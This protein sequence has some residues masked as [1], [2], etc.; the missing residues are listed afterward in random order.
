MPTQNNLYDGNKMADTPKWEDSTPIE[1]STVP[2][3][4]DSTPIDSAQR[5]P[6]SE[7]SLTDQLLAG[8]A[9]YPEAAADFTSQVAHSVPGISPLV[10]GGV[11]SLREVVEGVPAEDTLSQMRA[12][13]T[14]RAKRSPIATKIGSLGGTV[15]SGLA[16]LPLSATTG[17]ALGL[18][19]SAVDQMA[20]NGELNPK[21]LGTEA[22]L[23]AGLALGAPPLLRGAAS[24]ADEL[25]SFL[26][27][28]FAKGSEGSIERLLNASG[29]EIRK[30]IIT[31]RNMANGSEEILPVTM[32][33]VAE[34]LR[35]TPGAFD[36]FIQSMK[37]RA[38][39]ADNAGLISGKAVEEAKAGRSAVNTEELTNYLNQKQSELA[40][41]PGSSTPEMEAAL[42]SVGK[43]FSD[44]TKA[45]AVG[46]TGP[47]LPEIDPSVLST[48]KA[49]FGEIYRDSG[50]KNIEA[51]NK[52]E[53]FKELERN[54]ILPENLPKYDEAARAYSID[55][56]GADRLSTAAS[57]GQTAGAPTSVAQLL[58]N[59]ANTLSAVGLNKLANA[60]ISLQA[61]RTI[62]D[63][64]EN[65][66]HAAVMSAHF[67]MMQKDK[68]YAKAVNDTNS[69]DAKTN[70]DHKQATYDTNN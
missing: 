65:R 49:E 53:I 3:W 34:K 31:K 37:S 10:E 22:A 16:A 28:K 18:G 5:M 30:D 14:A 50:R 7:S 52:E 57:K 51:G 4:E 46:N 8:L 6:E 63:A 68:E 39:A 26:K 66:G 11:A 55:Q 35:N 42:G 29:D 24:K 19:Q 59:H 40:R 27:G 33:E 61:A 23:G 64:A 13:E 54:T 12:D 70:Q 60:P 20:Y 45:V 41:S 67:L 56:L 32:S 69:Q 44:K 21:E 1:T 47:R 25:A 58:R 9:S 36:S 48:R 17:I 15:A 43:E 38:A 62:A 2:K